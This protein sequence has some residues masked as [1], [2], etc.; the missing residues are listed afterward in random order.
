MRV[1]CIVLC[2]FL[3]L[4]LPFF[5]RGFSIHALILCLPVDRIEVQGGMA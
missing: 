2:I 1:T 5:A 3:L 4:S